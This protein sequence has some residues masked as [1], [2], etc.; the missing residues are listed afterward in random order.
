MAL[1]DIYQ[2]LAGKTLTQDELFQLQKDLGLGFGINYQENL[3]EGGYK[4][5]YRMLGRDEELLPEY[6]LAGLTT[7]AGD[8]GYDNGTYGSYD[9]NLTKNEDDTYTIG[10]ARFRQQDKNEGGLFN[11]VGDNLSWIGPLIMGAATYGSSAGLLGGSESVAA[12][13]G[14]GAGD[15]GLMTAGA[16]QAMGMTPAY[17][18][19]LQGMDLATGT[20]SYAP[21]YGM[22]GAEMADASGLGIGSATAGTTGT[23]AGVLSGTA[24]GGALAGSGAGTAA[25]VAAGTAAGNALIPNKISIPGLGDVSLADLAKLGIGAG[26]A[27]DNHKLGERLLDMYDRYRDDAD[28]YGNLLK[29]TYTD[30]S[31]YLSGPEYQSI[32]NVT[33]DYLQRKDA[34]G[35]SL[36]NN[37]GRQAKLNDLAMSNLGN[38]RAGLSD[39][40][41][42]MASIST[43]QGAQNATAVS[44]LANKPLYSALGSMFSSGT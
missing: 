17:A 44:G 28:Y 4:E 29:Q 18:S 41:R 42:G 11:W 33:G 34:A 15:A 35:G 25:Q 37:F 3:G 19:A 36:A 13:A 24:T 22:S 23:A 27:Y 43:G 31:S 16:G 30:P 9:Y 8:Y 20:G 38:Y 26:A 21:S 1:Q 40:Y 14:L 2:G 7:A 6:S 10:D 5:A 32:Q 12:G 39:T